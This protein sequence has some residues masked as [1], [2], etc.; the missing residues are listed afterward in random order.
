MIFIE[1]MLCHHNA[2]KLESNNT[3]TVKNAPGAGA[4]KDS[5]TK[6]K[7]MELCKYEKRNYMNTLALNANQNA[8]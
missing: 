4:F 5:W 7:K 6:Y 2:I 1:K 3:R 8:T